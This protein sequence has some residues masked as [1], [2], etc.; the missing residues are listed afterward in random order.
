MTAAKRFSEFKACLRK[1]L[2]PAGFAAE[3]ELF[4]CK[5][6]D[7]LI[8]LEILRDRKRSAKEVIRFTINVGISADALRTAAADGAQL[9][10]IPRPETCH[11][12]DRLGR[13]LGAES[14]VWWSVGSGL[15][16]QS[17]CD[18][19][20][21]GLLET[22]LPKVHAVASSDALVRLWQDGRGRGLTEYERRV[23]LVKMLLA[24]GRREEARVA[25]QALQD[26][27]KGRSWEASARYDVEVARRQLA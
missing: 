21:D 11:W 14:D 6:Q 15:N 18:E 16:T 13:L 20:A 24:L 7:V 27:S 4:S 19:I 25:V 26:S 9:S 17:V 22:A 10:A 5:A 2:T 8:V 1:R 23:N 3:G 12:R